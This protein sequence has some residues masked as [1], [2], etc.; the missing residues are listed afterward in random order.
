VAVNLITVGIIVIG[1]LTYTTNMPKEIF[2]EFS[3]N[4]ITVTTAYIGASAEEVE[5]N[6]TIRI[7]DALSDVNDVEEVFSTSQEGLSLVRLKIS[8]ETR[9]M[10]KLVSDVQQKVDQIDDF[11]DEA[12]DP[13]VTEVESNIPIITISLYGDVNLRYLK[14]I[15]EDLETEVNTITGVDDVL[16]SGLPEREMWVEV[17]PEALDRFDLTMAEISAAVRARNLDLPGGTMTTGQGEVLLRTVGKAPNIEDLGNV[18]LKTTAGGGKVRLADVA[19]LRDWFE[20]ESTLGRYNGRRAVNLNVT[21][22]KDG[23][24]IRISSAVRKLVDEYRMELPATVDVGV[25][26]DT[27]VYVSN[28]LDVMK[29]SGA[30]GLVIVFVLLFLMLNFRTSIMV[31]LGIP[32]SFL[33]A[34][35]LMF[36][37]GMTMNMLAMFAMIVVLGLVVDDAVVIGENIYRWYEQGKSPREAAIMGT[38]EVLWPVVSAVCTTIAA[39]MPLL[40]LP[41]TMGVFLGVIPKVVTFA[42]IISLVEALIILPSHMADFLPEKPKPPSKFRE[43]LNRFIDDVIKRYGRL[44]WGALERRYVFLT[45]VLMVS[46]VLIAYA[47]LHVPFRFFGDFEGAQFFVNVEAPVHWS[48]EESEEFAARAE[49]VLFETLPEDELVSLVTNVGFIVDDLNNIRNGPHYAQ[50]IVELKELGK[51][52][53]RRMKPVIDEV[54]TALSPLQGFAS[55]NVV[56]VQ[57]GPGGAP[58]YVLITGKDIEKLG[59]LSRE[60]ENYLAEFPGVYDLKNNLEAGKPELRIRLKP[61]GYALGLS[62]DAVAGELRNAFAGFEASTYQTASEDIDIRVKLPE[63]AKTDLSTLLTYK[64]R[65][66]GGKRIFLTEVAD[67]VGTRG[68]SQIV[69]VDRK[70]SVVITG[71]LDQTQTTASDLAKSVDMHFVDFSRQNPGYSLSTQ[72]GEVKDINESLSALVGAFALGLMIIYFI[73]GTQFKSYLQPLIV[74]SAIPCGINGVIIGHVLTGNDLG[75]MSLIGLTALSGI[76]VNDSLVLVDFVNKRRAAGTKRRDS[77]MEAGMLRFRPVLLTSLTTMGGLFFLAFFAKGQSEFLSPMA[78]SI[79]FG[80]VASTVITLFIVPCLYAALDDG[81]AFI[82]RRKD[83]LLQSGENDGE[84]VK[85]EV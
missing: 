58:I 57:A 42:L 78:V 2:P 20:K 44:L 67:I 23:D 46:V 24:A 63:D 12:E 75:I 70:R 41:G 81:V 33:G 37:F 4:I 26:N 5:K 8:P 50:L 68:Q 28:R 19:E 83:R 30:Q 48:L 45:A 36:Y 54:R 55:V 66:P 32:V 7:E 51:G 18:V 82:S 27:S 11:P 10:A 21:K 61:E 71:Q 59:R 25:F 60:V 17:N 1:I 74:L 49:K 79:F 6:L 69:R 47:A 85:V 43:T 39:F 13:D 31:T 72:R 40:L 15:V 38:N 22:T 53:E 16:I 77:L 84:P 62:E 56:E 9:S 29:T 76:V 80:L 73:L 65:L 52:R 3:E 34:V 35:I 64:V 14:D